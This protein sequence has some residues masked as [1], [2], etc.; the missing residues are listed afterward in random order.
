[1]DELTTASK[2]AGLELIDMSDALAGNMQTW[3]DL[4]DQNPESITA[5]VSAG[6]I[7]KPSV[8]PEFEMTIDVQAPPDDK[9]VVRTWAIET[10]PGEDGNEYFNNIQL[11]FEADDQRVRDL[12]AMGKSITRDDIRTLLQEPSTQLAR[13]TVSKESGGDGTKQTLG[14]RYDYNAAEL[15]GNSEEAARVAEA[16]TDVLRAL[17]ERD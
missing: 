8:A 5:T 9:A 12:V 15:N 11:T 10:K 17:K 4:L 13:I 6:F 3:G 1:M 16:L 7:N 14:E 2:Q